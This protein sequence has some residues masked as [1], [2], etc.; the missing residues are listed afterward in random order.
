MR[1][2]DQSLAFL[3]AQLAAGLGLVMVSSRGGKY[4]FVYRS[5]HDR[6]RALRRKGYSKKKA[7]KI[8]NAWANGTVRH[9]GGKGRKSRKR[10]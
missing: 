3:L 1:R 6:Y 9:S 5:E 2:P 10:K 7:A 8:A 4:G